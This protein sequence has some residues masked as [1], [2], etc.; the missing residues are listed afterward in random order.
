MRDAGALVDDVAFLDAPHALPLIFELGPAV[1]HHDE[2][3]GAVV[4]MPVLHFVLHFP[5]VRLDDMGNVVAFRRVLD[6][7]VPVFED[8]AQAL[9]PDGLCC[10][11]MRKFPIVGHAVLPS[12]LPAIL[13]PA[14]ATRKSTPRRQPVHTG[15]AG[16]RLMGW[17]RPLGV[18][19]VSSS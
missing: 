16:L 15:G 9:R 10:L 1:Q 3:E 2:L 7:E 4:D 12:L 18:P 13:Q 6:A 8:L 17:R 19:A 11:V 14:P 5:A